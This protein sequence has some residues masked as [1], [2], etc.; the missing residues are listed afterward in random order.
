M[1]YV[2]FTFVK[3]LYTEQA[4]YVTKKKKKQLNNFYISFI[5]RSLWLRLWITVIN[6]IINMITA[7]IIIIKN[8][9]SC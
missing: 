3:S 9:Y 6:R 7:G 8:L 5:M 4:V 1:F 2:I